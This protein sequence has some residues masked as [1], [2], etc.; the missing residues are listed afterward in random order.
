[1]L[2]RYHFL[3]AKLKPKPEEIYDVYEINVADDEIDSG[4]VQDTEPLF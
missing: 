2:F 4:S 3:S 1:M